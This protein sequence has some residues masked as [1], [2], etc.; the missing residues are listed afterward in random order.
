M[1]NT[2]IS[3]K[4][5]QLMALREIRS[6]AGGEFVTHVEVEQTGEDW[7]LVA[8]VRD[9]ADLDRVQ[10]AVTAITNRLKER[11]LVQFDW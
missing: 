3:A 5:L 6:F 8:T 4:H 1:P 2:L 10:Y 11:Y 9:G 7:A